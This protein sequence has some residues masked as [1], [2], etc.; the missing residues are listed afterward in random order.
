[1]VLVLFLSGITYNCTYHNEDDYFKDN[2]NIC[3]TEDRSF[4]ENIAPILEANCT[5]CHNSTDLTADIDLTSFNTVKTLA[6]SG[7]LYGAISHSEG[8]SSMPPFGAQLSECEIN[9]IEAW[10]EQGSLNN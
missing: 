5:S 3:Y 6:E 4:A 7:R 1:M 9:Q 8:Y 10:I 2:P